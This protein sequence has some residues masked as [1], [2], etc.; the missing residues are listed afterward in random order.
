MHT[1]KDQGRAAIIIMGHIYFDQDGFIAR[2]RPFF[3]WLY[4]HYH[5]DDIINMNSFKLYNKQGAIERT[6]LI[7]VGGRKL[8]PDGVALT[9]KGAPHLEDMVDSF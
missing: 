9:R 6:M 5:V 1:L 2:Y 4:R 8:K 7:L 3:N